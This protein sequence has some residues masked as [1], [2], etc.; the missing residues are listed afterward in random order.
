MCLKS[1]SWSINQQLF[2]CAAPETLRHRGASLCSR[3]TSPR[4]EA[5][6]EVDMLK[7]MLW[8]AWYA[9]P[10][11]HMVFSNKLG[12]RPRCSSFNICQAP[13]EL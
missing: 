3:Q 13:K 1:A 6:A 5:L 2:G 11:G 12:E 4:V 7:L 8:N 9:P 10:M